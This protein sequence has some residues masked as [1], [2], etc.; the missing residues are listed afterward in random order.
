MTDL[1]IK[2][3]DELVFFPDYT[4]MEPRIIADGSLAI[5]DGKIEAV[6]TTAEVLEV[7]S[8]PRRSWRRKGI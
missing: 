4:A 3:A 8:P 1:F 7:I 2:G 6:G 5:T